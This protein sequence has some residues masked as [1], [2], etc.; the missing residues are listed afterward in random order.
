MKR[1]KNMP[2]SLKRNDQ[3]K[4]STYHGVYYKR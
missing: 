3:L 4:L 1:L 2:V